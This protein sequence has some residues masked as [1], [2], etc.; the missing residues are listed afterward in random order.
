MAGP[1]KSLKRT[2]NASYS[3]EPAAQPLVA[4]AKRELPKHWRTFNKITYLAANFVQGAILYHL[5]HNMVSV[6]CVGC[7]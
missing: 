5:D 4:I 1:T 7:V 2:T 3:K 6:L